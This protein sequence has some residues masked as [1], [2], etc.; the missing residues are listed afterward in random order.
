VRPQPEKPD[1]LPEELLAWGDERRD[2]LE[3]I[4]DEL[5]RNGDWPSTTALTRKL[6]REDRALPLSSILSEMPKPIGFVE[7]HPGRIVLL[8]FGL[9]LTYEGQGLLAGFTAVLQTAIERYRGA[10]EHPVMT[11]S[12][13]AQTKTADD[14]FVRALSEIVLREA[15]FLGS[16]SES[17]DAGWR[18][19]ITDD[20]VRYWDARSPDD[21]LRIRAAE[22][23][24]SPHLGWG[25]AALP[26]DTLPAHDLHAAEMRADSDPAASDDRRDVFISHA[27]EDKA[28]VAR[29]LAEELTARGRRV[30][31]DEYELLPSDSLSRRID[32]GLAHSTLG[33]VILSKSFFRKEWPRRELDGLTARRVAGEENVIFPVWHEVTADEVRGFSPPLAD[34]FAANTADGIGAVADLIERLLDRLARS[35]RSSHQPLVSESGGGGAASNECVV[36]ARRLIGELEESQDLISDALNNG[37]FWH[38]ARECP[39]FVW[40]EDDRDLARLSP[41]A[42]KAVQDAQRKLN[43]LN[44]RVSAQAQSGQ[45]VGQSG[46]P[47]IDES[48][49]ARLLGV[50]DVIDNAIEHLSEFGGLASAT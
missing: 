40:K 26:I 12:D 44:W 36:M 10:D 34:V 46:T 23:R 15:P 30:W 25:P 29:P 18:R 33:A 4:V 47:A 42:H 6:A 21:Y 16:S 27:G 41:S 17:P 28:D 38:A 32:H 50:L 31:F 22:L 9:R 13:V 1:Y 48:N 39:A 45:A 19:E 11:L 35:S 43:D 24:T 37:A 8:L 3:L 7:N 14:P 5:L 20:V 49:R 2:L